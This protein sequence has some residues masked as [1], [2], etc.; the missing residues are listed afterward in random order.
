MDSEKDIVKLD[1]HSYDKM[2]SESIKARIIADRLFETCMLSSNKS[3]LLFNESDLAR[4]LEFMYPQRY[5]NK[6]KELNECSDKD[7]NSP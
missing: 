7:N 3:S 1:I 4:L 5:A 2:K 6:V